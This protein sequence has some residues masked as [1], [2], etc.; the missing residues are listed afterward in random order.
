MSS[1]PQEGDLAP[2]FSLPTDQDDS[3]TLSHYRTGNTVVYFYPRDDTAGCTKQ[4]IGFTECS[5]AFKAAQTLVVG[6]SADTVSKHKKF[7]D[8]YDLGIVLASDEDHDALEKYGVWVQK[9][10]YGRKYMGI[11]RS[12]FLID[13]TGKIARVWRKVKVPGHVAEVL[14]AAEA[15]NG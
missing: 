14:E 2:D 11:E 8:K 15:L 3:I 10:M 7:R 9:N 5:A 13:R 12:T 6:I 4:A 1:V